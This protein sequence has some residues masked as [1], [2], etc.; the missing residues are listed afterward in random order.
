MRDQWAWASEK[1]YGLFGGGNMLKVIMVGSIFV[2]RVSRCAFKVRIGI[3]SFK[4]MNDHKEFV[5][6][7]K[8]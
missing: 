7:D 6:V 5:I 4:R 8:L 2:Q 3:E 1:V